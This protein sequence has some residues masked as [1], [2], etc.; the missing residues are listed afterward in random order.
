MGDPYRPELY[1]WALGALTV[2][3]LLAWYLALRRR[4]GPESMAIGALLWPAALGV[5]AAALL[6]AMSYYGSLAAAAA[7]DR[8]IDCAA[9]PRTT[10]RLERGCTHGRSGARR[11][12]ACHGRHCVGRRTRHCL[13]RSGS[14]LLCSRWAADTA[15][16]R[17]RPTSRAAG[18]PSR[19]S[20]SRSHNAAADRHWANGGSLRPRVIRGKRICCTR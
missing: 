5:V 13:R 8:R 16:P 19:S 17:A 20:W 4:I 11:R 6:P 15:A 1:R 7:G 2:T 10:T 9:D 12:A 14:V 3:I 18:Q